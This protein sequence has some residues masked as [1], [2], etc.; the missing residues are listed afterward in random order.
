MSWAWGSAKSQGAAPSAKPQLRITS[1]ARRPLASAG[2]CRKTGMK[3]RPALQP[4]PA[5]RYDLSH[6]AQARVNIDHHVAF[7]GNWYSV[8]YA[9]T[10]ELVEVRATPATVEIFHRGKRVASHLRHRGRNHNITQ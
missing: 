4:L 3:D 7:D 10:G 1:N 2:L 6:W 8:P 5:E 9:L